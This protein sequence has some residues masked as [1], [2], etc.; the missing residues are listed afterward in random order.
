MLNGTAIAPWVYRP[1]ATLT[2]ICQSRLMPF[3]MSW[4]NQ[5]VLFRLGIQI[6][7]MLSLYYLYRKMALSHRA[8]LFGL[9]IFTVSCT[10]AWR[11]SDLSFSTYIEVAL[12]ALAVLVLLSHDRIGIAVVTLLLV[13]L[14]LLAGLNRE[15]WAVFWLMFLWS[16]WEDL[17][18]KYRAVGIAAFGIAAATQLVLRFVVF[19]NAVP[20][21]YP[22]ACGIWGFM[23]FNLTHAPTMLALLGTFHVMLVSWLW[24]YSRADR[25]MAA[26]TLMAVVAMLYCIYAQET[27]V[28]LPLLGVGMVPATARLLDSACHYGRRNA[29]V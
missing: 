8:S 27:R 28:I 23:P 9:A 29:T 2:I 16:R 10:Q 13:G 25:R 14:A 21:E 26:A 15:T 4:P 19:P 7:G 18:G 1:L 17:S 24:F 12:L 22:Q 20:E 11:N 3:S 5:F 6:L